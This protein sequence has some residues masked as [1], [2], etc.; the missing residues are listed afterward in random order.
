LQVVRSLAILVAAAACAL[1]AA[2]P[3]L[4]DPAQGKREEAR[5]VLAEIQQ[6]DG[7][8]S[9]AIEAYNAS[10]IKLE[11]IRAS[12]RVNKLELHVARGNLQEAQRRLAA[13]LRDLYVAGPTAST[14]EVILGATSLEDLINRID[15]V[16]RVSGQDVQVLGEVRRFRREVA[17]RAVVLKRAHASQRRIVAERARTRASIERRLAERQRRLASIEDEIARIEAEERRRQRLLAAQ[18]QARLA[19]LQQAQQE[20][21]QDAVVGAGAVSPEGEVVLPPARYGGVVGI[22]MQ[23]LGVPYQWGGAS[24]AGFDCSGFTMYVYA[25]V[26]VS[27]PHHAAA[28]YNYG[29]PVPR[30][31]LETG[32]LVF[33]NGLGHMGIYIGN[34]YFIHAPHTG[35]VVKISSIY[36]SWYASTWVGAK[37]LT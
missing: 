26:G 14:L 37:R 20:A 23:Y 31:Q 8:L 12:L 25:Q 13:R 30:D 3:A 16:D 22:A 29:I 10:T 32:D 4:G 5:R 7:Q 34:G 36:D 19:S 9:H 11:R 2:L 15:T 33:F 18:A 21:I 28:I 17:R 1:V 27:L 6:I 24:P 35:D